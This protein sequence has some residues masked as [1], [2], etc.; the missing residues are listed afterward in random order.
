[1]TKQKQVQ[2]KVK[3]H[4]LKGKSITDLQ[5][6]NLYAGRRLSGCIHRLR[7]PPHSMDIE[8]IKMKQKN[9]SSRYAKYYL[10]K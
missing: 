3:E 9:S 6:L 4:L 10:K 8:T 5:C 1:M 7:N 2:A